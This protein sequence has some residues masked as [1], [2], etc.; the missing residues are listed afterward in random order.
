MS[1]DEP[2]RKR[3]CLGEHSISNQ[4]NL[5][6]Q[7]ETCYPYKCLCSLHGSDLREYINRNLNSLRNTKQ[8]TNNLL[9]LS[10]ISWLSQSFHD[11]LSSG[12]VCSSIH[13]IASFLLNKNEDLEILFSLLQHE[14]ENIQ[15]STVQALSSILPL[16][17]CGLENTS[18]LS[19]AFVKHF[20][21]DLVENKDVKSVDN[22]LDL[23]APGEEAGLDDNCFDEEPV[24]YHH[25][26]HHP[27]AHSSNI[28]SL[29]YKSLLLSVLSGLVTH[30]DK[31]LDDG[32]ALTSADSCQKLE[33]S[34]D[35][36]C[37]ETQVKCLVI[38]MLDPVWPVF[39]QSLVKTLNLK[40]YSLSAETYLCEGFK[41]WQSLISVRANLS[42]IESRMFSS[43][44]ASVLP[45]LTGVVPGSVWRSA[46]DTVSECLCYGTTLGLQS[47]PPQEPC[48]LAHTLIRIV[49]FNNYLAG[50]PYK[51][52][53][54]MGGNRAADDVNTDH[55]DKGLVQKMVL[56]LLKCVALTT[57]E[58]RVES[59]S[60]ESDSSASSRESVSSGG[61]DM[62]IIHRTMSGMYKVLDSWIKQ[63]L[64][65]L[66]D[67]S[68]QESLLHILQE[69]DDVLIEGLL[70]LLDTHVALYVP[71]KEPETALLDTN[72][73]RGFIHLVSIV[74]RDSSVLLDFLVSN[75]TC[76][77][78]YFLRLL[79]F[80]S[81]NW[82]VFETT[83]GA[84]YPETTAILLELK[85][86][87]QR[88]MSK[89]LFPYNIGPV[90]RLLEKVEV[91]HLHSS[92]NKS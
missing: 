44:L 21:N 87:I 24:V 13:S 7:I 50:V 14:D 42:F 79:K 86:S 81:K 91:L 85:Q 88:L 52:S 2:L 20:I 43:D 37:Q 39:T 72:P 19:A 54:G 64:P 66:P 16:C 29:E 11:Q 65:V 90:F 60:G 55:Y 46:L 5:H 41:L 17:H 26:H 76:F 59:S 58:A 67:Q 35:A 18:T 22:L 61:S 53:L 15:F 40:S 70:C 78:L 28:E 82:L 71:G 33:L 77:L 10:F 75:E 68:L 74:S 3:L 89:S 27:E 38:K 51:G 80:I 1:V 32:P 12:F 45:R 4:E 47:I 73:A 48:D 92:S 23:V 56:I 69:Q 30:T 36:L 6:E 63:I 34:E 9:F 31:Q 84:Q 25:H 83:C 49:R 62:V 57:R 8:S